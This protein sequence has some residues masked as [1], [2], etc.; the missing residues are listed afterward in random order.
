MANAS[1]RADQWLLDV[2]HNGPKKVCLGQRFNLRKIPTAYAP[3]DVDQAERRHPFNA[4][5]D[6]RIVRSRVVETVTSDSGDIGHPYNPHL[7]P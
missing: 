6:I 3:I 4:T 1:V 5:R 7:I 2:C